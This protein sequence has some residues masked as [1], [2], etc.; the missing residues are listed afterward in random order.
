[1][2]D[3]PSQP[4]RSLTAVITGGAK[5]IGL[6]IAR[7]LRADGAAIALIGRNTVALE[8]AARTLDARYVG[9]DVT[10]P[11]ALR[12]AIVS[13]GRCDILVSNAGAASW[14]IVPCER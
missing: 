1:M 7:R 12:D 6:A 4:L 2:S 5:G 3:H 9:A 11:G 10:D 14:P 8:R 13:L